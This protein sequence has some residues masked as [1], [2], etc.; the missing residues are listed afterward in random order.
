MYIGNADDLD[1]SFLDTEIY[2]DPD[3]IEKYFFNKSLKKI[4]EF[5]KHK[6]DT[7]YGKMEVAL[8]K[9]RLKDLKI[10]IK[11]MPKNEVKN[12]NLI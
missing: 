11:Y 3:L 2:L 1:K 6:K 12:K 4:S 10:D 9:N 8:I 7:S 5:L